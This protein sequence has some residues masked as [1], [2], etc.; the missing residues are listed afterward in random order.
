MENLS[1][2]NPL[3]ILL[4]EDSKGDVMLIEKVLQQAMPA[5]HYLAVATHIESALT[6][7]AT[8]KF[9]VA[10]LDRT[11]PDS[12]DFS[13]LQSIQ[14]FAPKLPIIFLTGY[15]DE[16][17]ACEAILQGAQEYLFKESLNCHMIK[18]VMQYAILRKQFEAL[19]INRAHYDV[20]TGL[21]N[22][23]L[24]E[25]RL[26]LA[27]E[28]IKRLGGMLSVLMLDLDKFKLINDTMGHSAGDKLLK[29]IGARL[30]RSLRPYDTAARLGG[31]EFVILIED[32]NEYQYCEHLASKLIQVIQSPFKLSGHTIHLGVSIGITL[33]DCHNDITQ[34]MLI[35]QADTAMYIAKSRQGNNYCLFD[36]KESNKQIGNVK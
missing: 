35:K 7:L 25:N 15:Q 1:L 28:K 10:L 20:L 19:L 14:N 24:F 5:S 31:D 2:P 17:T 29:E 32:I 36:S 34:E 18:R 21:A 23:I 22:R 33:C 13:G 12:F 11:L 30:K 3:R 9:D 27:I 4:V 26:N 8:Q 6:L 16:K